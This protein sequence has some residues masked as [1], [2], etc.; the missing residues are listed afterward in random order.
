MKKP[1]VLIKTVL[2]RCCAF[3]G[4]FFLAVPFVVM[5]MAIK[6]NSKGPVFFIAERIGE[7][8]KKFK[9]YKFR[10]MVDNAVNLGMGIETS[11]TDNRITFVGRFLRAWSLDEFP[12]LI[13]ILK[14]EMS[15]IGPRPALPHQVEKYSEFERRR[16]EMRPGLTGW[17]QING[18]NLLSWKER[19]KL[20]VW[21]I[22][23]WSLWLDLKILFMTPVKILTK[24]GLYGKVGKVKDYE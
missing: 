4:L 13:N 8:C 23:N 15:L 17:A 3:L 20:D 18:R 7:G 16:F 2:D 22:D 5:A 10:T 24:E 21:Y 12:Q 14:G 1:Y 11:E 9:A 6:L 19:I